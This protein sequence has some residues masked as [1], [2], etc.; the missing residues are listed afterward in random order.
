[1]CLSFENKAMHGIL[2][3]PHWGNKCFVCWLQKDQVKFTIHGLSNTICYLGGHYGQ[4]DF[5][6]DTAKVDAKGNFQFIGNSDLDGG[7]YFLI[8][9]SKKRMFEIIII[10][11]KNSP[12]KLIPAIIPKP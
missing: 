7:I 11:N 6:Y 9:A 5:I 2:I 12:W 8:S 1:M 10:K 3:I 4:Y